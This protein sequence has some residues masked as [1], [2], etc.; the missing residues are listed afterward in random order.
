MVSIF[1][2]EKRK[3]QEV[4]RLPSALPCPPS[5]LPLNVLTAEDHFEATVSNGDLDF[6]FWKE[7]VVKLQPVQSPEIVF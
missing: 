1:K 6:K 3:M 2:R 7:D 4:L 5:A